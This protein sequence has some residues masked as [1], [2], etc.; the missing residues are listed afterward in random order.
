[1]LIPVNTLNIV[2]G[3]VILILTFSSLYNY[4][5]WRKL[6]K[7]YYKIT[8][9]AEVEKMALVNHFEYLVKYANDI[10]I[11][12]NEDMR[13]VDANEKATE[14][15]GYT[16]VE[17]LNL[18]ME[19]IVADE[20]KENYNERVN[21]LKIKGSYIREA[22][23]KK[24]D[25]TVFSVEV[26]TRSFIVEEK[27][28]YQAIIRDISERKKMELELTKNQR[29]L[30]RAERVAGFGNWE[31]NLRKNKIYASKGAQA[32]FGLYNNK[33]TFEIE[34][35]QA[36]ALPEH[37]TLLDKAIL[38]LVKN[39]IPYDIEYKILR[40]IDGQIIDIHSIA[41]FDNDR[42]V[43]FGVIQDV[44]KLK[45]TENE[46][47]KAKQKAEESDK[48]K[49]AFLA[50]MSHEIRTP[51]NGIVGFS[52]MLVKKNI[53]D[54][55]RAQY[56][57]LIA[58][59]TQQ[60]LSIVDD[61]LDLSKIETG[62][63][64]LYKQDVDVNKFIQEILSF[65]KL[66]A[67]EKKLTLIF[68]QPQ[69]NKNLTIFTDKARLMQIFNN[70]IANAIKFTYAG[71]VKT[72]YVLKQN[73]I[74]FYVEDS[75]IGIAPENHNKIFERFQQ[76]ELEISRSFGGAGLGLAITKNLVELLG[77]R[78]WVESEIEKGST[79]HFSLPYSLGTYP[80]PKDK[81]IDT[82]RK[83]VKP[84]ILTESLTLL[85]AEDEII[86]FLFAEEV[87]SQYPVKLLHAK[88]GS[89]AVEIFKN[90][91]KI[92]LVLMDIKMP[93]MN[94][95]EAAQKIR[96]INPSIPIIALTA[97][98]MTEDRETALRNG[99]TD[100]LSKPVKSTE[101]VEMVNKYTSLIKNENYPL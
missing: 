15:Y 65:F 17:M 26:S 46:L 3:L 98:A 81:E 78:I 96:E 39:D 54:E 57:D 59:S 85:Y 93:I 47:K 42:K 76:A 60:L 10:I 94:G 20:D 66:K 36:I 32:I 90:D 51:M 25:G 100:Y 97:Y 91:P 30:V 50:N 27:K 88:N 16:K 74:E 43:I 22:L 40:P 34:E 31:L 21:E 63:I 13:I 71:W 80:I 41:E 14:T 84:P 19:G 73:L 35:V 4:Y 38:D 45:Q 6:Q 61:I 86:N 8:Y 9:E 72:G 58:Q 48:L 56:A 24:K 1:M 11:L 23:H 5:N 67:D 69:T 44:T 83:E 52:E 77:G 29:R 99:C 62:Q 75:G 7:E 55:K 101:L 87:F 49:S 37:R 68:D 92:D 82:E 89:E 18:P 2:M 95:Y 70:L 33:N 12:S 64:V 79:F 28:Y 53:S